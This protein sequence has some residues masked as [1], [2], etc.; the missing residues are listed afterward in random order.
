M[1][2]TDV[3]LHAAMKDLLQPDYTLRK[4]ISL[5][6]YHLGVLRNVLTKKLSAALPGMCD[7]ISLCFK[8]MMELNKTGSQWTSISANDTFT[9]I[10]CRVMNRTFIGAP[11]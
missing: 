8:D 9:R 5:D 10:I 1:D 2:I 3:S 7:E 4:E 11:L 6:M